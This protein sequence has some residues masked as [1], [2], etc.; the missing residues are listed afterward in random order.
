VVPADLSETGGRDE[1]AGEIS[2][3][4]LTVEVLC[5]NAGY[6]SGGRFIDLDREREVQMVRLNCAAVVDLCARFAPGM[7]SRGRG[8][9]LNVASTAAFQPIPRQAAYAA[10]KAFVLSFSEALHQELRGDGVTVTALCPGPVKTEFMEAA[11]MG[12]I[13]DRTPSFVWEE[14]DKVAEQAVN[15][16]EHGKRVVIP[17]AI[18]RITA[19]SGQHAPR[20]LLLRAVDRLYPVGRD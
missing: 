2:K 16:L 20:S 6:G 19:T 15:A 3:L 5:N 1:L 12:G 13:S 10:S 18:N 14:A 7:A 17:G 8:A 11:G 4:G 9:I